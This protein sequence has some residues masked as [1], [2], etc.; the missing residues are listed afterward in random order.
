MMYDPK[1]DWAKPTAQFLGRFQPWN[2]GHRAIFDEIMRKGDVT[3]PEG[4]RTSRATQCV[5]MVREAHWADSISLT[6]EETKKMIISDLK[7]DY[8]GKFEVIQ[9]PNI[10]NI[11][12]GRTV[13][14][15]VERIHLPLELE[16]INAKKIRAE[17]QYW[18]QKFWQGRE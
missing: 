7:L 9:V 10:T 5:I 17:N 6:F 2:K 16:S 13:G 8:H 3:T 12:Y 14:Y 1:I 11:F 4:Y 18:N 15:D